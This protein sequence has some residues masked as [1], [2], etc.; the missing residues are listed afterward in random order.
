M[1]LIDDLIKTAK[2]N[3]EKDGYL[4]PVFFLL[5]NEKF[6]FE[7]TL[8]SAFDRVLGELPDMEETKTRAVY[9]IGGM[10]KTVG[11]NRVIMVWDGAFRHI[12]KGDADLCLDDPTERP[13]LY[14][15]SMRTEC[16]IISDFPIGGE[17]NISIIPY[18][19]GDGEPVEF[20]PDDYFKDLIAQGAHFETRFKDI[21][22]AG[23]N[24]V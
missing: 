14:P 9:L 20:L 18:K 12:P 10:A 19:G 5:R 1:A 11:A 17:S 3:L 8:V 7:P 16:I 6:V 2:Q 13:L 4:A 15:K 23:Y 21:L 22:H 24:K